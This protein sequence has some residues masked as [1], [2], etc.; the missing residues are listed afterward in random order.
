MVLID[1]S[2]AETLDLREAPSLRVPGVSYRRNAVAATR[3]IHVCLNAS[4]VCCSFVKCTCTVYMYNVPNEY[5]PCF[6][7][8]MT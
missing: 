7:W 1:F 2:F 4:H 8:H 6:N 5:E 3:G